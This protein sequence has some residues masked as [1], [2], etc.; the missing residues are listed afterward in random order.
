MEHISKYSKKL[1]SLKEKHDFNDHHVE[2]IDQ[3][4]NGKTNKEIGYTLSLK[5][6]T[7][8]TYIYEIFRKMDIKGRVELINII[9]ES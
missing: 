1:N 9:Q 5:E 8:K 7:V 4:I 2:I 6:S 3:I